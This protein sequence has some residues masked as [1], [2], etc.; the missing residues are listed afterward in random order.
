MAHIDRTTTVPSGLK[1]YAAFGQQ[2]WLILLVSL[3]YSLANDVHESCDSLHEQSQGSI[4]MHASMLSTVAMYAAQEVCK[5][6]MMT[7]FAHENI[8]NFLW[9]H[10]RLHTSN[11][12]RPVHSGVNQYV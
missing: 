4:C 6:H 3:Q 12:A 1:K 9:S 2:L 11:K 5:H 8:K 7:S 10:G